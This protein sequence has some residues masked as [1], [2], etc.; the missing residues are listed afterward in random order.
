VY[1]FVLRDNPH[2][3]IMVLYHTNLYST[4]L[5]VV[6][7]TVPLN[8]LHCTAQYWQGQS[9]TAWHC[10]IVTL[11]LVP[12]SCICISLSLCYFIPVTLSLCHSVTLSLCPSVT[13]SLCHRAGSLPSRV[14]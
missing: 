11:P 7:C 1:G 3:Y 5:M 13:L 2:N 10:A 9:N 6:H 14:A 12:L 4:V 8:A